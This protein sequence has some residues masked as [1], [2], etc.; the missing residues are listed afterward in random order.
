MARKC[1]LILAVHVENDY[2]GLWQSDDLLEH[3]C[4]EGALALTGR[5]EN[6]NMLGDKRRQS[7]DNRTIRSQ[8]PAKFYGDLMSV[9]VNRPG[10]RGG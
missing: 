7:D 10:I 9:G 2:V 1:L 5:A 4:I 8:V 3:R 6:G